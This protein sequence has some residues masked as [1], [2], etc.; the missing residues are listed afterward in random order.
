MKYTGAYSGETA[1]EVGD[2]AIYT[3]GI[4][5]WLQKP[6]P[7]GT[8]CYE[9]LYWQRV[10]SPIAEALIALHPILQTLSAASAEA[11]ATKTVVDSMLFDSKTLVL[12]SSTASSEK[13]FAITV[14]D[15]GD[16]SATEITEEA[17]EAAEGGES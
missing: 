3:D 12:A 9:T 2:I 6:A 5:Y 11:A 4:P 13:T 10:G 1:Y 15:D 8:E 14:D 7:V 16:I 17:E